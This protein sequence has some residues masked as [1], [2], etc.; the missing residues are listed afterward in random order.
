ML[1]MFYIKWRLYI[2]F[3]ELSIALPLMDCSM[4]YKKIIYKWLC[5]HYG[6]WYFV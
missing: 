1:T 6:C 3:E 2:F 4:L 5:R